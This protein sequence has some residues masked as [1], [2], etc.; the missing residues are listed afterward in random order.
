MGKYILKASKEDDFYVEWSSN[1]DNW[2]SAGSRE[3]MISE[4]GITENRLARADLLG[5]TAWLG[6]GKW[7][8]NLMVHNLDPEFYEKY[9][10]EESEDFAWI[11]PRKNLR[12][13]VELTA[14]FDVAPR[15][16]QAIRDLL[17]IEVH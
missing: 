14:L 7:G 13:F 1:V 3:D 17:E 15:D 8:E 11:L 16:Y 10:D 9:N 12:A 4:F 2:V 5:S 6:C